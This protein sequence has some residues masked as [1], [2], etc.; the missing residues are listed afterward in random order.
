V[1]RTPSW[2]GNHPT[3]DTC[4]SGPGCAASA[5]IEE[6][7]CVE[8][9]KRYLYIG[10]PVDILPASGSNVVK[11]YTDTYPSLFKYVANGTVNHAPAPGDVVSFGA[12]DIAGHTA[13]VTSVDASVPS[14]GT[15]YL[16]YMEENGAGTEHV[17]MTNWSWD[18]P[19]DG[20][21]NWLHPILSVAALSAP[22]GP[23]A[24]GTSVTITGTG[25][26]GTSGST[27]VMFG[28]SAATTYVVNS[29]SQINATSPAYGPYYPPYYNAGTIHVSVTNNGDSSPISNSDRFTYNGCTGVTGTWAILVNG[30]WTPSSSSSV[31]TTVKM[32]G[33]AS[34]CPSP[35]YRF[36]VYQYPSGHVVHGPR[37]F[38]KQYALLDDH[39]PAGGPVRI[40]SLGS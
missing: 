16:N 22:S 11:A 30:I 12:L 31:G 23:A 19:L 2:G 17:H 28:A 39:R 33:S 21:V 8:L 4:P 3:Y 24:G 5:K 37:L 13:L 15:G 25:F 29:G 1:D 38:T 40:P 35:L 27:G 36:W 18:N 32:S 20:T 26:A 14:T 6:W 34:G 7:Q 9:A 10:F